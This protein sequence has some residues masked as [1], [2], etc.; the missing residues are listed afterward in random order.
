M[1][2]VVVG[3]QP[4]DIEIGSNCKNIA[5]EF[6]K[7]NRVIYVNSPLDRITVLRNRNDEKVKKRL[8][9]ISGKTN[10]LQKVKERLWSFYPNQII[11][12]INWIK[13]DWLY[14]LFNKWNNVRFAKSIARA[15][16]EL[17]FKDYILF[18]DSDMFRSFYLK[19]L[20]KPKMTVYYSRDYLLATDYY[21]YHGEKLEPQLINKSTVCVANSTYLTDYCK[22]YNPNSY[23][24]GQGCDLSLFTNASI[25]DR[26]ADIKDING[27]IIGYV[28]V[29]YSVRLDVEIIQNIA[30][31][32]PDWQVVLVGPEDEYFM[33]SVLHQLGNV[34][35]LGAKEPEEL[36]Q[37]IDAFDVCINP[38]IIT[39]FTIGNYPR[40]VDEYLAMGKPVVATH[41]NAMEIFKDYTYLAN[42]KEEYIPLIEKALAEDSDELK[43]RRKEFVSGHTWANSVEEIYKAIGHAVNY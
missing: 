14:N 12:S 18:N 41:T 43:K 29:I 19:E 34:H 31:S 7:N 5:L 33:E 37:Y 28:G 21:R 26:P 6:S 35:F 16:K 32:N 1:D 39:D 9:V 40:K 20:L 10:G 13:N 36:P 4:W 17:G 24:V 30:M 27:P 42:T 8:E 22:K 38:Q 3:Q 2:I 11:E 25:K 15:I 23:Y